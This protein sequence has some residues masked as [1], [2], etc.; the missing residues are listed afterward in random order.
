MGNRSDVQCR[1]HFKQ[2]QKEK[3]SHTGRASESDVTAATAVEPSN[4]DVQP[5][6]TQ[7]VRVVRPSNSVPALRVAKSVPSPVEPPL[8][9]PVGL[10]IFEKAGE[11][12]VCEEND[13]VDWD[14]RL[15]K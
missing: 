9:A 1:Y 12:V 10:E 15:E 6:D 13:R 7:N 3:T 11:S 2:M 4:N 14:S 5:L 8:E